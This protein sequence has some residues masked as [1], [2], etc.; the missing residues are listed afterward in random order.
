MITH[1]YWKEE[2]AYKR[3]NFLDIC[4]GVIDGKFVTGI[5]HKV[6]DFYCKVISY[7]FPDSNARS[8]LGYKTISLQ[9][10]RFYRLCNNKTD[11]F[12]FRAKLANCLNGDMKKNFCKILWWHFVGA[13]KFVLNILIIGIN[14]YSLKCLLFSITLRATLITLIST[15]S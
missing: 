4:I 6:D 8:M 1:W 7:P 9:L 2:H 11:F 13:I 14:M 10:V 5:Y 15:T 3:D 12:L